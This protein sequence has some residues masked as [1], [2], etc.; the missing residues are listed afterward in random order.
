MCALYGVLHNIFPDQA[1]AQISN[2]QDVPVP[3]TYGAWTR[4]CSLPLGT[5]NIQCE[6]VQDIQMQNRHDITL[7][8][9]F[10]K[11]PKSQG[12]LMRIFV[13]IRVELRPGVGI[14]IDDKNLEKI[15]Y[16]RCLGDNC[17][18]ESLL[19]GDVLKLFL[20]GKEATCFIFTTPEKGVG[21]I[22]DLRGLK[23]AYAA[24]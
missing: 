8:V 16:R 9:V 10:Y 4:I 20:E 13:P 1:V 15:E 23:D 19:K 22:I 2:V 3:Q 11:L 7:R 17:V 21:G 14:K 6:A 18:A 12:A 5:L 24:L